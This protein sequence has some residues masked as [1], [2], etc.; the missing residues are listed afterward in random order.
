MLVQWLPHVNVTLNAL[1]LGLLIVGFVLIKRGHETVH[2]NV[3]LAALAT[4]ILFL[5]CYLVYH[6]YVPSKR[7]PTDPAVAPPAARY[8]YYGLLASHVLLAATVPF[9]ALAAVYYGW[10]DRRDMHRRVVRWAWP[11]WVYVSA[12]GVLVYLM[13]YRIYHVAVLLLAIMFWIV[14]ADHSWGD[15]FHGTPPSRKATAEQLLKMEQVE[16]LASVGQMEEAI[17]VLEQLYDEGLGRL[18]EAGD[19]QRAGTQWVQP[20]IPLR[21]WTQR[22]LAELLRANNETRQRY[23]ARHDAA[24]KAAATRPVHA[25][26]LEEL[27][28][29]AQRFHATSWGAKLYL[30]LADRYLER[31]WTLPAVDMLERAVPELRSEMAGGDPQGTLPW[32]LV[33]HNYRQETPAASVEAMALDRWGRIGQSLRSD[34][35]AQEIREA[36]HRLVLAASASPE[37]LDRRAIVDWVSTIL[38]LVEGEDRLKTGEL[39]AAAQSWPPPPEVQW[40]SEFAGNARRNAAASGR[41]RLDEWPVWSQSLEAFTATSDKTPASQ[42]RVGESADGIL[43][44][45]PVSDGE[46]VYVNG[47]NRIYAYRLADGHPWPSR[48]SGGVLFDAQIN[49]SAFLPLGYPLVGSPRGT[50]TLV[51][52]VLYARMGPPVTGWANF[53]A[54]IDG[55]SMGYLIALDLAREG[56]LLPGFPLRLLPPTF[57]HAEIE[58][59]PV[60]VDDLAIVSVLERDDVGV[61][62][63]VAAFNRWHGHLEWYTGP[64]ATGSVEGMDRANLISHQLLSFAGGRLFYNTNLGSIVC[65][66]PLNGRVVWQTRYRRAAGTTTDVLRTDRF[67]YRTLTP[68]LIARGLVFCAPQDA[69]E[70]FALDV[71]DGSLVWATDEGHVDDAVHLL[72]VTENDE[73]ICS[74]DYLVWLDC[75]TGR[76]WG[77]FPGANTPGVV[78][79]LPDPRGMGRGL[80]VDDHVLWPTAGEVLVLRLDSQQ[81]GGSTPLVPIEDGAPADGSP[82]A[83][84]SMQLNRPVRVV[85]RY[86]LGARGAEGGN[87]VPAGD[88]LLY[89][90]PRRIMAFAKRD[91]W[92]D[93]SLR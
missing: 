18:V 1:A 50:L 91:A 33:W 8:F 14:G 70:I 67:R 81:P 9:F 34:A 47:L 92:R 6:A 69:A 82:A 72:G 93:I 21:T 64:L 85:H 30:A 27:F 56:M 89:A 87:L 22:K 60:I 54:A 86:A 74:G 7:F 5:V 48:Q 65:L 80:I 61:R 62:R 2:R 4:S 53:E 38:P 77:R 44:F 23:L 84:R 3:M 83:Q 20:Y 79:A 40:W 73:L 19:V 46:R 90:S 88:M 49:A 55:G 24:A 25:D 59:A 28:L 13:L 15:E 58:G 11:I 57:Q 12:T 29:T 68:C 39:V 32:P 26:S 66:D 71:T 41:F 78:H 75:R 35:R 51:D 37:L 31:G 52:G 16:Q 63:G 17:E 45:F 43:A 36:V 76:V 42:P 10:R